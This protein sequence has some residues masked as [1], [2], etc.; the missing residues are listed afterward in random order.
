[1]PSD[2]QRNGVSFQPK[3]RAPYNTSKVAKIILRHKIVSLRAKGYVSQQSSTLEKPKG[4][5]FPWVEMPQ[6]SSRL[7]MKL[8]DRL[9]S[10]T[11]LL[12]A[13]HHF[14][15]LQMVSWYWLFSFSSFSSSFV[16]SPFMCTRSLQAKNSN[17]TT[18]RMFSN[19]NLL[20][21]RCT[22]LPFPSALTS[23]MRSWENQ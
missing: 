2:C 4:K 16:E 20:C 21:G 1:M 23:F 3:D 6:R 11:A 13:C 10:H 7:A 8:L 22:L 18:V 17:G 19:F 12:K 9:C 15:P 5:F 14:L